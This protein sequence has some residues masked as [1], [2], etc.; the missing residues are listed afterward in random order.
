MAKP[1]LGV[2]VDLMLQNGALNSQLRINLK[3]NAGSGPPPPLFPM[4]GAPPC[5]SSRPV[6]L[7]ARLIAV[8]QFVSEPHLEQFA[9]D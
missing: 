9:S 1:P 6:Y 5:A 8:G 7:G 4:P 2:L 3:R